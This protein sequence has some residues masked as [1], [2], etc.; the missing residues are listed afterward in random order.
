MSLSTLHMCEYRRFRNWLTREFEKV[1]NLNN[2]SAIGHI[3]Y[4]SIHIQPLYFFNFNL[5][6]S[7][8]FHLSNKKLLLYVFQ[9]AE[10][11]GH[12]NSDTRKSSLRLQLYAYD[13]DINRD[14]VPARL[15][16]LRLTRFRLTSTR[17]IRLL[18]FPSVVREQ[19]W[20]V[21][22]FRSSRPQR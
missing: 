20:A 9:K 8:L 16:V 14:F 2:I 13:N 15:V 10:S 1:A 5:L 22:A 21:G 12:L 19:T 3:L 4:R 11:Q 7:S 17:E 18:S 6:S